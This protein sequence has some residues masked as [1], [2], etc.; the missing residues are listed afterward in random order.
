MRLLTRSDFDGLICAVLL[1]EAGVMDDWQFIHPKDVQ[2]GTVSVTENDILAN[3]PYAPGCGLWFDHHTSEIQRLGQDLTFAGAVEPLKSCARVIWNYYGGHKTFP[4][5]FDG[6][7]T[8]VDRCDSGDLTAEEIKNPT[9]WILL[10]FIMDPRTG[11]GRYKDYA[12][13][14]YQLMMKLVDLCRKVS[15][16]EILK[17]PDVRERTSR[18][19]SQ[20]KQFRY[21]LLDHGRAHGNVL[22]VDL[23]DQPEIFTGNRFTVYTLFPQCNVSVWVIWGRQRQNIVIT[24]GK[25][26]LDRTLATDIGA[27]MLEYGGGGHTNVGT[28]QI[29]ATQVDTAL[30][31]IVA[32]LRA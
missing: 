14:N 15:V 8:A 19:F 20:E 12:I 7:L 32:R 25:S 17:D 9:G 22:V 2:D 3:V 24:V 11:L 4:E 26:I 6:M 10:S 21:M 1:K 5:S 23:R 16:E 28:C 27:L 31:A 13:S 18:Y 29:P 30:E